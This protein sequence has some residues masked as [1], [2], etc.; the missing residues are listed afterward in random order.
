MLV[1]V[2]VILLGVVASPVDASD[3]NQPV[4]PNEGLVGFSVGLPDCRAFE[5]VTPSFQDGANAPGSPRVEALSPSGNRLL[6]FSL[7]T[8]AGAEGNTLGVTYELTRGPAHWEV[9]SLAPSA[10]SFP[11]SEYNAASSGLESTIWTLR[12]AG[13]S[14]YTRDLYRRTEDGTFEAIGPMVPP[15]AEVGPPAEGLQV[16]PGAY[17]YVGASADLARVYFSIDN[18]RNG[19][20]LWPGDT[21]GGFPIPPGFSLYEYSGENNSRPQLVGVNGE[22]HLISDCATYLG[23]AAEHDVYNAVSSDGTRTVFTAEGHISASGDCR[24]GTAAPA[25]TELYS[26]L[27][28]EESVPISEPTKADCEYCE[29]ATQAPAEFAGASADGSKIFFMTTQQLVS[30]AETNNLYE[31]DFDASRGKRIVRVSS[32]VA[33]PEVLGVARVSQDGSHVYFVA[34]AKLT[35]EPRGGVNGECLKEQ[36]A[37]EALEETAKHEGTCRPKLGHDNL[38]LFERNAA[39]L[40]GRLVFVATLSE[41]DSQDWSS[42]DVRPVQ[43]T[44]DGGYLALQSSGHLL[45]GETAETPQVYEYDAATEELVRVSRGQSG[46]AQGTANADVAGAALPVQN[47]SFG[48]RPTESSTHL[49]IAENGQALVFSSV[50]A[51]TAG[52]IGSAEVAAESVYEYH[53]SGTIA[54]G[55][56]YLLSGGANT[57]LDGLEG[58]DQTGADVVFTAANKLVSF[59]S[60]TGY[61]L[62]D[63]RIGGGFA[64]P[65]S[66]GCEAETCLPALESNLLVRSPVASASDPIDENAGLPAAAKSSGASGRVGSRGPSAS[67]C[68]RRRHAALR[69]RC[70]LEGKRRARGI[71]WRPVIRKRV[72]R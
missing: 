61:D 70:A 67:T 35:G 55:E 71:A 58:I 13:S 8:F 6:A 20:A 62:Y 51:L 18:E 40:A 49:G 59:D 19:S 38:Y 50:A 4:C 32:G 33:A 31:F 16:S 30:E 41:A 57:L 28:A 72:A 34:R 65:E 1:A 68:H 21:T 47:F 3:V 60:N 10:A 7:G 9:A 15:S 22:G 23:S 64:D 2:A 46:Y 48:V 24:E 17:A 56:V 26:R 27:D 25:V 36:S 29:T 54:A 43:T 44:P 42:L 11:L 52:A 39:H 45:P 37:P 63:A 69:A 14:I 53:S 5:L 12:P 66:S